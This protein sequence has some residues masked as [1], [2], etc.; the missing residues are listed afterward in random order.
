MV[1]ATLH[2]GEPL[3]GIDAVALAEKRPNVVITQGLCDV[4]APTELQARG[5]CASL[6]VR[7]CEEGG[8]ERANGDSLGD[9][10]IGKDGQCGA[11]FRL[12]GTACA[13]GCWIP[14]C[15][16]SPPSP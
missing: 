10:A 11:A 5:A 3:Y 1:K 8:G 6:G 16:Q 9:N 2:A 13:R 7:G 4:C 15:P 14:C 12:A